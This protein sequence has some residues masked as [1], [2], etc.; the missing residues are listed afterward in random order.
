MT[1]GSNS[2]AAPADQPPHERR[3]PKRGAFPTPKSEI[4]SATP[5][6]PDDEARGC[7]EM[8]PH[9]PTDVEGDQEPDPT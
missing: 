8:K 7:P 9:P 4:E 5:Y 2:G 1:N 3:R 6:I